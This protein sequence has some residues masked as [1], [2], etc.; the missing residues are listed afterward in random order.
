LGFILINENNT[1]QCNQS[2]MNVVQCLKVEDLDVVFTKLNQN[3]YFISFK[4]ASKCCKIIDVIIIILINFIR[5]K[6]NSK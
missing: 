3:T 6:Q 5:H 2:F 4:Q 1:I